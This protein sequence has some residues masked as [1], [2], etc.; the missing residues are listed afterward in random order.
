M[1]GTTFNPLRPVGPLGNLLGR[2][3]QEGEEASL[4]TLPH[5]GGSEV[6][7]ILYRKI[8]GQVFPVDKLHLDPNTLQELK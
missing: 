1:G 8:G 5:K 3:L 4:L 2:E 7:A 6:D